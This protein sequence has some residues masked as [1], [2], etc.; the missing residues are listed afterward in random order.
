M[1]ALKENGIENEGDES[2]RDA[3]LSW[4]EKPGRR[5]YFDTLIQGEKY[6]W[7]FNGMN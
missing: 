5:V 7:D 6:E 1:A 2:M 3:F 4:L